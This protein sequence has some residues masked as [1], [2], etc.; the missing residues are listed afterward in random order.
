MPAEKIVISC[1]SGGSVGE[2][3]GAE[4]SNDGSLHRAGNE[5]HAYNADRDTRVMVDNRIKTSFG[6]C[7]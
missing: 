6:M 2:T 4:D 5:E 3:A 7:M 1:S